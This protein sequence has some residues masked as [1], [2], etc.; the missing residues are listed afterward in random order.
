MALEPV[1][2][3]ATRFPVQSHAAG[4]EVSLKE[5]ES[6]CVAAYMNPTRHYASTFRQS[7][8]VLEF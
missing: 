7:R 1:P 3:T 6:A 2:I 8:V 4:N 5:R